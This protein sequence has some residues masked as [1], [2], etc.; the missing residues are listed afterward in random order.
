MKCRRWFRA[1]QAVLAGAGF[2][3]FV[4]FAAAPRSVFALPRFVTAGTSCGDCHAPVPRL[5]AAGDRFQRRGFHA[6]GEPA[7]ARRAFPLSMHV[8][9]GYAFTSG[10]SAR[11]AGANQDSRFEAGDLELASAGTLG[12]RTSIDLAGVFAPDTGTFRLRRA[13]VRFDGGSGPRA[14]H[15]RAGRFPTEFPFLAADRRTTLRRYLTPVTIDGD[16]VELGGEQGAW[17]GAA[18]LLDSQRNAGLD[19]PGTRTF[20]RFEDTCWSLMHGDA[21][22]GMGIRV[23]FDRQD[24]NLPVHT[25][26]QHVQAAVSAALTAGRV[27]IVPAY[28]QDRFDDRPAVKIHDKFH[29]GLVEAIGRFGADDRWTL[30][31][32]LEH[33]YHTRTPLTPREDTR[34]QVVDLT[35]RLNPNTQVAV[36]WFHGPQRLGDPR[37]TGIAARVV[38]DY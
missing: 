29:S 32:R 8:S 38:V 30:T 12:E 24:S 33:V 37:D 31:A 10:D 27:T 7:D 34:D 35:R 15:V 25:W 2:A 9:A 22:R 5:N 4:G 3:G 1:V 26:L 14:F 13:S 17:S 16:G 18:A 19:K 20:N 23:W 21:E 11:D 36:E 28:V 6:P